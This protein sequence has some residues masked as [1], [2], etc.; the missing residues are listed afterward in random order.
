MTPQPSV[1]QRLADL[2]EKFAKLQQHVDDAVTGI[3]K[4]RKATLVIHCVGFLVILVLQM[5]T[6]VKVSSG[7]SP[8]TE[9]IAAHRDAESFA[10]A[11]DR[12]GL[13]YLTMYAV[14]AEERDDLAR[15]VSYVL[16]AT[17]RSRI[18]TRPKSIA[19]GR[20][21]RIQLRDYAPDDESFEEWNAAW[22]LIARG[23]RYWI[24]LQERALD[25]ENPDKTKLSLQFGQ[26][27][28]GNTYLELVRL[29]GD[30]GALLRADHWLVEASSTAP[31]GHYYELAGVPG[32]EKEFFAQLNVDLEGNYDFLLERGASLLISDVTG[33]PRRILRAQ[34]VFG[35]AYTTRDF[36][37]ARAK[38]DPL[39]FPIDHKNNRFDLPHDA[40]ETIVV[41]MN[42]LLRFGLFDG[43]GKRVDSVPDLIAKDDSDPAS[44]GVLRPMISCVR[45]HAEAGLRPFSDDFTALLQGHVAFLQL[46]PVGDQRIKY[47]YDQ[48]L[49]QKSM[50]DDRETHE[51]ATRAATGLSYAEL[52]ALLSYHYR[53]YQYMAVDLP[54]AARE[55][56]TTPAEFRE[57]LQGSNDPIILSLIAG[58]SVLRNQWIDS[59]AEAATV[60]S[61][62]LQREPKPPAAEPPA[63]PEA[64]GDEN[65]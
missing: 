54:K 3:E 58:R 29:V 21:L 23:D 61:G 53:E 55:V 22:K 16:N 31:I 47:F 34:S 9:L 15:A 10:N 60:I 28:P 17:S 20:I 52:N 64:E 38:N 39:R 25:P 12:I 1:E 57:K 7:Q 41:G 11:G 42:G 45:C 18:I 27:I 5:L 6:L 65:V 51:N 44:D 30:A 50:A 46:N 36:E 48:L 56:G 24:Q 14:P 62:S 13:R 19:N 2:E 59:F 33:K 8:R 26:W 4:R 49:L 32:T 40:A 35:G 43:E 37:E 63:Q